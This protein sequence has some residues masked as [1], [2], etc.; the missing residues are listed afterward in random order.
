MENVRS[1]P[2]CSHEYHVVRVN[3]RRPHHDFVVAKSPRCFSFRHH[4]DIERHQ[5]FSLETVIR[6]VRTP[7][8]H[9]D[10]AQQHGQRTHPDTTNANKKERPSRSQELSHVNIPLRWCALW[11]LRHHFQKYWKQGGPY[12][13]HHPVP[14]L[15]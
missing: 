13:L 10:A 3:C 9:S 11:C 4:L 14:S 8:V 5:P 1:D 15:R 6:D 12:L 7:Y 2:G